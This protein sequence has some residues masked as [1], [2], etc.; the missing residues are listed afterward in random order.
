MR[1]R[2]V[3]PASAQAVQRSTQSPVSSPDVQKTSSVRLVTSQR[4]ASPKTA[5][6][7]DGVRHAASRRQSVWAVRA[8]V[9]TMHPSM[10]RR[11]AVRVGGSPVSR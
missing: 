3:V 5:S 9:A 2:D 4:R 7:A 6:R 8:N 1:G 10:T 11:K